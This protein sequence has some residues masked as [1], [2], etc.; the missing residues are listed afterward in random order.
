MIARRL[1]ASPRLGHE[2]HAGVEIALL[3]GQALIDRVADLVGDTTPVLRA[4]S[5]LEAEQLLLGEDVPEAEIHLQARADHGHL[6]VDQ[7]LRLD[8]LPCGE[9]RLDRGVQVP[10]DE[11]R[12]VQRPEQAGA[13]QVGPDHPGDVA[14]HLAAA[15]GRDGDRQG[16][17]VAPVDVDLDVGA[18]GGGRQQGR[19]RQGRHRRQQRPFGKGGHQVQASRALKLTAILSP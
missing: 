10:L 6:A 1:V 18:G 2:H 5:E 9:A 7:G 8:L 15:E 19:G 14:A 16:L 17:D 3:A 12:R 13:L 11:A 4:G